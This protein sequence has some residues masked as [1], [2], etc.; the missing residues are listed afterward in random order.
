MNSRIEQRIRI[1]LLVLSLGLGGAAEAD[2][3][4]PQPLDV[5]RLMELMAQVESRQD[6]FTE[7]K[8]LTVLTEPMVLTGTLSYTR[9]DRIEKHVLTP[10]EEHLVV[11]GDQLTLT[12]KDGTKRV[13]V[14]SHPLIWSFVEAIRASL[15]GDA[16]TLQRFYDVRIDGSRQGWT[17]TL[18]PFDEKAAARLTSIALHGKDS[19]LTSVEII[20]TGGDQS[21]MTIH[22]PAS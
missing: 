19:R 5:P 10:Y 1:C 20:E 11:Q 22:E 15:A 6:R 13:R 17:L 12:N 16:A 4:A 21:V 3:D 7:T 8:T 2:V 14:K 18:R 9:P